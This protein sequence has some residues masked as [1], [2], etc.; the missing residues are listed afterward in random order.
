M[1]KERKRWVFQ[2]FEGIELLIIRSAESVSWQVLRLKAVRSC[3][4][5][6]SPS[7]KSTGHLIETAEDGLGAPGLCR[8]FQG[9]RCH[10]CNTHAL[11][12]SSSE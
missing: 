5:W 2:Q 6:A 7:K 3:D 11:E 9:S 1:E 10:R 8:N 12:S 4:F